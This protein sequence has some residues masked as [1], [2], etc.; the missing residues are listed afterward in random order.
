MR[1]V[2]IADDG[3]EFDN[4]SDCEDYEI[5]LKLTGISFFRYHNDAYEEITNWKYPDDIYENADRIIIP[6][7]NL[8]KAI[9]EVGEQCGYL[10]WRDSEINSSGVWEYIPE[11]Y[12]YA[13]VG[14]INE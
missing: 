2:Y 6:N 7:D 1:T 12:A 10:A 11:I 3:K 13:K 14:D 8:A 5:K 9:R 4:Y